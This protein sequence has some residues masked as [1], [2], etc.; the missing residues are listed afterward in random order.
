MR[1]LSFLLEHE[2]S[3]RASK[4]PLETSRTARL[5]FSAMFWDP[6]FEEHTFEVIAEQPDGTDRVVAREQRA[7]MQD[8]GPYEIALRL[9]PLEQAG[10]HR[11]FLRVDGLQYVATSQVH[12]LGPRR[13][14]IVRYKGR[15]LKRT[16][17][18]PAAK[19]R[20]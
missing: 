1:F 9:D 10:W 18:V 14:P 13:M 6:G 11:L 7:S 15:E 12:V 16:E 5:R 2:R 3:S 20:A 8:I 17:D 4:L 19:R